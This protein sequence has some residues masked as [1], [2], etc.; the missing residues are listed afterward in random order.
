MNSEARIELQPRG[1][2][3]R[4]PRGTLLQ[5]ALFEH[6]VEFPC[7]GRGDCGGC[8]VRVVRGEVACDPHD[9]GVV[10]AEDLRNGWRLACRCRV[11]GD[12][13]LDLDQWESPILA[14]STPFDFVPRPGAAIAVDLGTTT[15]AAQLLDR[16]GGQVLAVRTA[17]N[18]QARFGAD[19]MSRI[20]RAIEGETALT[21][22]VRQRVGE[23]VADLLRETPA[24]RVMRIILVGNTAMHHL[25][26]GIDPTPLAA[27]P[28]E[29][30]EA[31]L[32]RLSAAQLGWSLDDDIK[33]RFLPCLGG[34]VGSDV[35]AGVLATGLAAK[36]SPVAL[37]DLGTNGEV[38]V[39]AGGRMLC[40]S[41]AA[42]PALEGARIS[43]GMRAATGAISSVVASEGHLESH[44]IGGGV[45]RGICGS[46]LV[47]AL[48]GALDLGLMSADGA[49]APDVDAIRLAEP[50]VVTQRDVREVQLAKGA[51]AAGLRLLLRRLQLEPADLEHLYLA[52]A[53]G[54]YV[55]RRSAHR[56][57]LLPVP[58][59][60]VIPI[61]NA[62]LLGAKLA[63]FE[64][65]C[66]FQTL[67]DRT[68]HVPLHVDPGFQDVFA[69]EMLFPEQGQG[70]KDGA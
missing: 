47:D 30:R 54:N 66:E 24:A 13:T 36:T 49:L 69:D 29:P 9:D 15:I 39:A 60:R 23:I 48:A 22:L 27:V 68:E 19:V 37:V 58:V 67:R 28:F 50:V 38:V 51:I 25:F 41:T 32:V 20:E 62:A 52:G 55:D 53:F 43:M 8:R 65:D 12:V 40:A 2:V 18:P 46:G 61:G 3:L 64:D 33:I 16:T 31:G 1:L 10:S 35:L 34:F 26:C 70:G 42:G 45:P 11:E 59:E 21:Q 14:D 17:L 44:V 57:G 7:G 4:L 63:T 5:D 6:G 56:I